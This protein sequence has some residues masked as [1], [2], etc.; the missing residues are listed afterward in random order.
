MKRI[1]AIGLATLACGLAAGSSAQPAQKP[2]QKPAAQ[3]WGA[4]VG[5]LPG[6]SYVFGNPAAKA[7]LV[8]YLSYTC[9][10]CAH[11]VEEASATLRRDYLASGTT[12]VEV[13]HALR[14]PM[15]LTAALLA[16][17][18]GPGRFLGHSEAI[19]AAQSSWFAKG[20]AFHSA[21]AERLK[22]LP[23]SQTL[24][25]YAK[26]TGLD[27]LMRGRGLAQAR[28]DACLADKKQQDLLAGMAQEA[29]S[30][31]KIPG[32]PAFLINGTLVPQTNDWAALKPKLDAA[33]N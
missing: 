20:V 16:R 28:I 33:A 9:P 10:H 2:A 29:W 31:R 26:G 12:S 30:Q 15:D 27:A 25:E 3:N 23:I 24:A 13:R 7:K 8:E 6:G 4:R 21:N 17:C 18:D 5:A 1:L 22:G 14:D 11:F 32:T 19:F